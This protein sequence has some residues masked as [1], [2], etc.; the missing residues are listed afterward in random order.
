MQKDVE[1]HINELINNGI[2]T[3]R[4]SEIVSPAFVIKKKN[5]KIRLVV[6]YRE[7]NEI[8]KKEHQIMPPISEVLAK[9]H[10]SEIYSTIDLNHG[11]YQIKVTAENVFKTVFMILNRKFVFLRM[12]FGLSN[13]PDSFKDTMNKMFNDVPNVLV[14]LDDI[15]IYSQNKSDHYQQLKKV[16]EILN[17]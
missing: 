16:F 17:S 4:N 7:L 3:V 12:S 5:D 15:L 6:D 13:A 14:Y 11:Y 10:G 1:N 2:I 8:T 9:L